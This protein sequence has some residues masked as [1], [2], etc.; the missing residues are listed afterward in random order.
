MCPSCNCCPQPLWKGI[1]VNIEHTLCL[2]HCGHPIMHC[3][4]PIMHYDH[5]ITHY[6]H[7]VMHCDHPIMHYDHPIMH[8]DHLI[9][10]YDHPIMH[11][12]R[13]IMHY[14]HPIMHYGYPLMHYDTPYSSIWLFNVAT[15]IGGA[16]IATA[17]VQHVHAIMHA[18]PHYDTCI[19]F[20]SLWYHAAPPGLSNYNRLK[21]KVL[22]P[23]GTFADLSS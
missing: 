9:T 18:K 13:P 17:T 14:D 23:V 12:D 10:H 21:Y 16:F 2:L 7:P 1:E 8:Y 19:V 5:S 22:P 15:C 11:Y 6:D 4:H 20:A 3:D